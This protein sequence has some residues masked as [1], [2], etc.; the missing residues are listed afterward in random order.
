[1]QACKGAAPQAG[2]P[3][4][5]VRQHQILLK[6]QPPY[7]QCHML[8]VSSVTTLLW[9]CVETA[10]LWNVT[11]PRK[12]GQCLLPMVLPRVPE[13]PP[14]CPRRFAQHSV[15]SSLPAG[16]SRQDS[17]AGTTPGACLPSLGSISATRCC[18]L[19]FYTASELRSLVP[20]LFYP[21]FKSSG[22]VKSQR[23][24]MPWCTEAC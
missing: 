7:N 9:A 13:P 17:Q 21:A 8:P 14:C 16:K 12:Y 10:T 11:A 3:T 18:G 4:H 5:Q 6:Q 23:G 20:E 24:L 1:M 19:Q 15:A 2:R 22:L